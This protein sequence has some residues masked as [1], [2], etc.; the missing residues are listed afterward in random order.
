MLLFYIALVLLAL[1]KSQFAGKSFYTE[2][3]F[4]RDVTDSIKGFFIW[5]VFLSHFSFYVTYTSVLDL[6]GKQINSILGQLIV[7]CFLF[8]SF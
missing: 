6:S 4:S 7:A 2:E 3:I 1:Y 5:L 8:Y